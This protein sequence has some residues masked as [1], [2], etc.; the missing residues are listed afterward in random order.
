[1]YTKAKSLPIL[2]IRNIKPDDMGTPSLAV[3]GRLVRGLF[4]LPAL[5]TVL[6]LEPVLVLLAVGHGGPFEGG[7]LLL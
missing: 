7:G 2:Y 5:L 3:I 6:A 4:V 1:M